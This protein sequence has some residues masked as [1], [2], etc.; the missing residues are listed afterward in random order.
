[1]QDLEP[2]LEDDEEQFTQ[3]FDGVYVE[4][5]HDDFGQVLKEMLCGNYKK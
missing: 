5:G 1:M 2:I 3:P 4:K